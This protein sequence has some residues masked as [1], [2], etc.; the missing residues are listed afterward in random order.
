MR[1]STTMPKLTLEDANW[2]LVG[3][4]KLSDDAI[5]ITADLLIDLAESDRCDTEST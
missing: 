2:E 4:G 3:D 5:A 1:E